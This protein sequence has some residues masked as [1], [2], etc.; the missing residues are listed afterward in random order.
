MVRLELDANDRL[1]NTRIAQRTGA[2]LG[3]RAEAV[4]LKLPLALRPKAVERWRAVR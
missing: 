2:N 1:Q 3:D 4:T